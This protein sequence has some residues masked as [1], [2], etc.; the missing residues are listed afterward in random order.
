[1]KPTHSTSAA[2]CNPAI[3]LRG[4][5]AGAALALLSGGCASTAMKGTP[6]YSGEYAVRQG[7][8]E[9][10]VNV[11][12]LL[13]YRD[14]ALSVLWPIG[15]KTEDHLAVRPL[16]S[17]YGMDRDRQVY[18]VL[19][20]LSEF[21]RESGNNYVFPVFWGHDYA[22]VF[23]LYWHHG[24]P[25]ASGGGYDT[26]LP[27]WWY[28]RGPRGYNSY[29]LG[30]LLHFKDYGPETGW[31]FWPLAGSYSDPDRS[32]QFALWPLGHRW[33]NARGTEGGFAAVP[34]CLVSHGA[35]SR[36]VFTPL[37]CRG[38]SGAGK[39]RWWIAPP[40][41]S[42]GRSTPNSGSVW[43]LG[44]LAHAGWNGK[45]RSQHVFPLYY[46]G[47][48]AN[49]S[50][51]LSLPYC[52]VAEAGSDRRWW[53][54]PPALTGARR[55]KDSGNVW[56][57]GP[58]A[59]ASWSPESRAQHVLPF[60]Y[61]G[62]DR[63]GSCFFSLPWSAG[64]SG[65]RRWQL[66]PLFYHAES[67]GHTT[68]LTP[69]YASGRGGDGDRWQA[70]FPLYFRSR[71]QA[72]DE[73]LATLLG[74][75]RN[76]SDGSRWLIYPLL[77]WGGRTE[78]GRDL[79]LGAPLFHW[80]ARG[81][82]VT[83][84]LLPFYYQDSRT[85]TFVSPLAARWQRGSGRSITVA[86]PLLAALSARPGRED[87][88]LGGGLARAS[89]GAAPGAQ[90][91]FPLFYRN[92]RTGTLATP[93]YARWASR[94]GTNTAVPP[95]LSWQTRG[96]VRSDVWAAGGLAHWSR[97][98]GAG[99]SYVAP[100]YYRNSRTGTF[101]SPA[102]VTWGNDPQ[103]TWIVPPLLGWY[104]RDG[105]RRSLNGLLGL[106]QQEWGQSQQ[107]EG[108]LLPLYLYRGRSEFYTPFF[109]W[110]REGTNGFCYPLTPLLGWRSGATRGGWLFPLGYCSRQAGSRDY[111]GMVLWGGYRREGD[112]FRSGIFPLY[113][114][115]NTGTPPAAD[116]AGQTARNTA[117]G[118]EYGKSYW[119]LPACWYRNRVCL[120][121]DPECAAGDRQPQRAIREEERRN[122]LF[123]LW[124]YA[125]TS[126]P[127]KGRTNISASALL[128]LYDYKR[129]VR[130]ASEATGPKDDYTRQRVLWRL[131]HY[132]R[133]NGDVSVDIFPAIT[134][135]HKTDGCRQAS[136]LWR[137]FRYRHDRN[138]TDLDLLFL[139]VRRAKRGSA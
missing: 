136:F 8:V 133:S 35:A 34:L 99:T 135:D 83:S 138:G 39:D 36:Q 7:P 11:W 98:A 3:P 85:H 96:P 112:T 63:E 24:H 14:P 74:G 41:L 91:V 105:E 27:L 86:P 25:L 10:R 102:L 58:L 79:W 1:M 29:F 137:G 115:R 66:A 128:L 70:L 109:G 71:D 64:S 21:D 76:A 123:P 59:H 18:S 28:N 107:R 93:A 30:P 113:G 68:L 2:R 69:L 84:H 49:G 114:Y 13:Y 32:Y 42:G 50:Q 75:Y 60:Y 88:W 111:N 43:G 89:W 33:S 61:R 73:M 9:D 5:I 92:A 37:Y 120:R 94:G 47:E 44:P 122:G 38:L 19:W 110:K 12:P 54:V 4:L 104:S 125:S 90:H 45:S 72:G 55:D 118:A 31:H 134:Y 26:L 16:F 106:W 80:R 103:R 95:L 127:E 22:A 57:L 126:T 15:E 77:S 87:L 51:F 82:E 6:F 56:V 116:Q 62:A 48:N 52:R 121:P 139:P 78:S 46:R 129:Q 124:H 130:P 17:V 53:A 117:A 101:V 65:D 40:V 131:W 81:G 67:P 20:P 119:S 108:H 23:P 132:E 100:V 97:G